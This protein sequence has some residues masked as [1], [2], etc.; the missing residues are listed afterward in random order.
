[1]AHS[2]F[3]DGAAPAEPIPLGDETHITHNA[4]HD[5]TQGNDGLSAEHRATGVGDR[6][7]Q[8]Q[9]TYLLDTSQS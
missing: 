7:S 6:L 2:P 3:A 9:A 8:D 4:S 5:G 1:M